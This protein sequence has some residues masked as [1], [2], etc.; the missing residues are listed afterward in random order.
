MSLHGTKRTFRDVR[1][2]VAIGGK[3]DVT[4][5]AYFGREDPNRTSA[6]FEKKQQLTF[7]NQA[8]ERSHGGAGCNRQSKMR[9]QVN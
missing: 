5:N 3:A 7:G 6:R 1:S 2:L 4:R 8:S 9:G